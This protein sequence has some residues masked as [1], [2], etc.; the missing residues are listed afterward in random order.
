MAGHN[1]NGTHVHNAPATEGYIGTIERW[2]SAAG[3]AALVAYGA[4][5]RDP[6]GAVLALAGGG[7]LYRGATG[8][9]PLYRALGISSA[10]RH[11][12]VAS[13]RH[14]QGIK[15]ER[16][17][18]VDR[19]PAELYS[20]W[21]TFEN[22]PRF[23]Q[24]LESVR[25]T[26]DKRSHW[27]AKGPAGKSVEWDAEIIN[28]QEPELIAWR[29]LDGADVA[30][31]GSVRFKPAPGDRGTEV[32]VTLEYDPPGGAL[33]SAVAGLFGQDPDLQVRED[34]RHFKQVVEAGEI[35]TTA[36]QSSGRR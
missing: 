30:N 3:G 31:A 18:T 4:K 12:P 8:N 13:L 25:T 15:V 24:H 1:G 26:G 33:G 5:R 19:A 2:A 32:H 9:A 29:S 6:I 35:P 34:L 17:V 14:G 22:L 11:S 10:G 16:T 23:M 28:E 27:V 21:R 36:G 20:L 7:A